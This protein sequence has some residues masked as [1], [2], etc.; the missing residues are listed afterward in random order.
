MEKPK[1]CS[2]SMDSSKNGKIIMKMRGYCDDK[3][4]SKKFDRDIEVDVGSI[5]KT[6]SKIEDMF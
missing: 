1:K 4:P 3:N 5:E 6:M 2:V